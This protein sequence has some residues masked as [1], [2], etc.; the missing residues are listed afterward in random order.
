LHRRVRSYYSNHLQQLAPQ[1]Q[2]RL[3]FD[4]VYLHRNSPILKP[5]FINSP[6]SWQDNGSLLLDVMHPADKPILEAM[7]LQHEGPVAL[8]LAQH[9]FERQPNSVTVLRDTGQ[10]SV[11]FLMQLNLAEAS[12]DDIARDPATTNAWKYLQTHSPLRTSEGCLLLRFWMEKESHQKFSMAQGVIGLNVVRQYL[13]TPNLAYTFFTCAEPDFWSM[14]FA[15]ADFERL[16]S[17]D[18]MQGEHS[19]GVYGHNWRAVGALAWLGLLAERENALLPQ[20]AAPPKTLESIMVLS[21]PEFAEA[22]QEA[23]KNLLKLDALRNSPLVRSRLVVERSSAN[24]KN[25]EVVL[26]LQSLLKEAAEILQES[27]REN[28]LYRVIYHTYLHPATTQEQASELLD[29]PFSTFR[30]HLKNGVTR[31]AEIMWQWEL[32]TDT[33]LGLAKSNGFSNSV[34]S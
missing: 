21:E 27:P 33:P 23:L 4:Y 7:I 1:E 29:L 16:L 24:P 8:E 11:A 19:Y 12:P 9:W 2:Q 22:V 15:Y 30:R 20:V 25:G 5:F 32:Q 14:L 10:K 31:I 3:L 28:K 6:F 17:A 13:T 34:P 26:V 18:F